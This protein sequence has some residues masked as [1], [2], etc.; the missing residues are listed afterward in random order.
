MWLGRS[1][2]FE[3]AWHSKPFYGTLAGSLLN[4]DSSGVHIRCEG[5]GAISL[6]PDVGLALT[7]P[8]VQKFWRAHK[9]MRLAGRREIVSAGRDAILIGFESVT[10]VAQVEV[11]AAADTYEVLHASSSVQEDT[12]E[13]TISGTNAKD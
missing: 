9:R 7:H 5:C 3:V 6:Q 8:I 10:D 13:Q 4:R 11:V 2:D 12:R 1:L